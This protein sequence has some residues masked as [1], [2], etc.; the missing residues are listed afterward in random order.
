MPDADAVLYINGET[1]EFTPGKVVEIYVKCRCRRAILIRSE[2]LASEPVM[3]FG[4]FHQGRQC[5]WY[6]RTSPEKIIETYGNIV[7]GGPQ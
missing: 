7:R 1:V 5:G 2:M 4:T 3:E 6:R